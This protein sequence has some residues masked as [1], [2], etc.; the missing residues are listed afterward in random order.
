MRSGFYNCLL[1]SVNPLL[2]SIEW[3]GVYYFLL[4]ALVSLAVYSMSCSYVFLLTC[5]VSIFV[6]SMV[7]YVVSSCIRLGSSAME[8]FGIGR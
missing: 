8:E 3:P 4:K 2:L 6:Y 1:T 5:L 7:L